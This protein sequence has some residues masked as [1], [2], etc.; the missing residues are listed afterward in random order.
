VPLNTLGCG[1]YTAQ[2]WTR[3]GSSLLFAS[4]PVSSCRWDR[5]LD[6][7][8]EASV[9]LAGLGRSQECYDAIRNAKP[10]KHELAL[11]RDGQIVWQ[12]PIVEPQSQGTGGS[13]DA[14]DLSAWWDHRKLRYDRAYTGVDLATVF[15]QLAVDAMT[16][17]P[18]PNVLVATSATGILGTRTY[19]AGQHLL[20]GPLLRELSDVGVDWT[21]VGRNVIA[22][23]LVVPTTPIVRL[24]DEHLVAPPGVQLEGLSMA[25][26]VTVVGAGGGGTAIAPVFGEAIDADSIT[27]FGLLDAVS[28]N[29]N[30]LDATSAAAGAASTLAVS[31][32]PITVAS[33]VQIDSDAPILIQQL[34]PGALID[35]AWRTSGLEVSGTYRLSKVSADVKSGS[36]TVTITIQPVGATTEVAA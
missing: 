7:T 33:D 25:N 27:E 31:R 30:A 14:R 3:G 34:V 20:I 35:V 11:A 9:T 18:T 5:R 10:W 29:A 15:Q 6:D 28:T 22:G 32:E 4:L 26:D 17:D 1:R 19:Q 13:Y 23:G 16:P 12:G 36:E 21:V 8:S 24:N 2:I